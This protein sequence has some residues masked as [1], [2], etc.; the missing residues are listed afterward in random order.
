VTDRGEHP[1]TGSPILKAIAG[2]CPRCGQG[3]LF[4][5]FLEI[6]PDCNVCGLNLAHHDAADGPAVFI[7]FIVG[8]IAAVGA[9]WFDLSQNPPVWMHFVIWPVVVTGLSVGLL[10]PFKGFFVGVQF[11]Y[12]AVDRLID[13]DGGGK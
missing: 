3:R 9:V 8:T 1:V 10:R 11:K 4:R 12:R 6:A 2:R 5:G 13:Q 7:T